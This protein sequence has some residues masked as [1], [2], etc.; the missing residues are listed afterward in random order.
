MKQIIENYSVR[1]TRFGR[2]GFLPRPLYAMQCHIVRIVFFVVLFASFAFAQD[3][4]ALTLN[5][6]SD[7]LKNRVSSARI[8]QLVEQR[9]VSFELNEAAL[10]QLR[11]GGADELVLSTVTRMAARYTDEQQRRKRLEEASRPK[12]VAG[13]QKRQQAIGEKGA[14]EAARKVEESK[15]KAQ[16]ETRQ[17]PQKGTG[18]TLLP[19]KMSVESRACAT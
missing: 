15:L 1:L 7:L 8:A 14:Q 5:Q 4:T 17:R 6:I 16:E 3:R 19:R 13:D 2:D 11:A 12:S 18:A 9:G 10:R